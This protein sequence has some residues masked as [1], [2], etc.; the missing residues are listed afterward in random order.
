MP[1]DP[2]GNG[3]A[4]QDLLVRRGRSWESASRLGGQAARAEQAGL[5]ENGI[6]FGHGISVSSPEANQQHARD[7]ND[8]VM[9][10]REAFEKAGFEVRYTP[11]KTDTDHHTI[12]LPK[13]VTKAVATLFNT[14]LGRT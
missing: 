11:T 7:P 10:T 1:Y 13:P 5:A 12:I 4:P 3:A 6:P 14:V 9:A 8:A 2:K